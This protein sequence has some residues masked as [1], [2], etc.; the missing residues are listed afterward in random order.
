MRKLLVC[1]LA[2]IGLAGP[3][4][5]GESPAERIAETRMRAV[6]AAA[7]MSRLHDARECSVTASGTVE[8]AE[9]GTFTATITVTGPC[10]ASLADQ[11]REAIAELRAAFK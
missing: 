11:M 4:Q 7:S 5:A 8:S 10:D 3:L 6:E 9:L 1:G 2:C